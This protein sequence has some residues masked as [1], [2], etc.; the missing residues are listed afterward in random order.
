MSC[1]L[2][3]MTILH[4]YLRLAIGTVQCTILILGLRVRTREDLE[5]NNN[6]YY[7][8][9]FNEKGDLRRCSRVQVCLFML[10]E[11]TMQDRILR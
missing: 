1:V 11:T 7:R 10:E 4:L 9:R 8:A 3:N 6:D 5:L 2:W